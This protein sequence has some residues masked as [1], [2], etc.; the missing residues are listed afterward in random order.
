MRLNETGV[1]VQKIRALSRLSQE[2]FARKIGVSF[3]TVN[4]W[5]RNKSRPL[6][7][8]CSRLIELGQGLGL[9]PSEM[10]VLGHSAGVAGMLWSVDT[11]E[12]PCQVTFTNLSG[13]LEPTVFAKALLQNLTIRQKDKD[14]LVLDMG[15]GSGVLAIAIALAGCKNVHAVDVSPAALQ[16][17]VDNAKTNCVEKRIRPIR[18]DLV[19]GVSD[20]YDLVVANPPTFAEENGFPRGSPIDLSFFTGVLGHAFVDRLAR[21]VP[22]I[23]KPT[24]RLVMVHPSYLDAVRLRSILEEGGMEMVVVAS[25]R[26]SLRVY[27][28][29][30]KKYGYDGQG[31]LGK[32]VERC[33]AAGREGLLWRRDADYAFSLDVIEAFKATGKHDN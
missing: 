18:S 6:P 32:L 11:L 5:E 7:S 13:V 21:S 30:F 22:G 1:V 10:T 3:T 19:D 29:V 12:G 16:A 20:K 31:I 15:T 4:R 23:L 14:G 9:D 8:A 25:Q 17:C 2:E 28:S 27:S 33:L 24:G 26:V